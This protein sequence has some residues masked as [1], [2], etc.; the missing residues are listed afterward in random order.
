M[1]GSHA[2]GRGLAAGT[3]EVGASEYA[4]KQYAAVRSGLVYAPSGGDQ[5]KW[6]GNRASLSQQGAGMA[7]S[8]ATLA[9]GGM[10]RVN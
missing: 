10:N 4:P 2:A 9:Q 1:G 3:L 6:A 8:K 5:S 7:F